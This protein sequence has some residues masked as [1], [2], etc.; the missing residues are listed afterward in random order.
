MH[1]KDTAMG[2]LLHGLAIL[3][4]VFSLA[5]LAG[6]TSSQSVEKPTDLPESAR[7]RE[8]PS[9]PGAWVYRVPNIN[10]G[11]YTRYIV[12]PVQIYRGP[13]ADFAGL[14]DA[15]LD[16]LAQLMTGEARRAL[17]GA[18]LLASSP[19]PNTARI[20][21]KVVRVDPTTPGAATVS[22]L[23]PVGAV[24]NAVQGAEG[25][26]GTFTGAAVLSAE[27]YD[28]KTSK[29]LAAAVRRYHPATF[30]MQATLSTMDTA[31]AAVRQAAQDLLS[32]L[33]RAQANR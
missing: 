16:E 28:S 10:F 17:G 25:G 12:D 26:S 31:R 23:L 15:Q 18:N 4:G 22:R 6:C 7:L 29:L 19:G 30:N 8:D 14:S 5:T 9:Q 1:S 32:S 11:K 24:A 20:V 21:I 27:F 3:I 13:D 33:Q 2:S